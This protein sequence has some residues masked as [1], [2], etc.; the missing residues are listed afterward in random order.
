MPTKAKKQKRQSMHVALIPKSKKVRVKCLGFGRTHYFMSVSLAH[1]RCP[2][3]EA[4][5]HK[6]HL[7]KWEC[8]AL[9]YPHGSGEKASRDF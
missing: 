7:S 4:K 6:A 5:L 9:E 2:K 3:C 8:G 1:R